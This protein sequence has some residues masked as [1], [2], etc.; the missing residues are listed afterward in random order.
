MRSST[1]IALSLFLLALAGPGYAQEDKA[2][3]I[4]KLQLANRVYQVCLGRSLK[5]AESKKVVD[6]SA[7]D[8]VKEL[9]ASLEAKQVYADRLASFAEGGETTEK[10]PVNAK[11]D[12]KLEDTLKIVGGTHHKGKLCGSSKS[13]AVCFAEWLVHR[14][15][16]A[17]GEAWISERVG[18][19]GGWS[20]GRLLEEIS[21]SSLKEG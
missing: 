2:A 6:Q 10:L 8:L 17:L 14:V 5:P 18:V 15:A 21:A 7:Q 16:P 4:K 1:K 19:L 20:Y 9:A 12:Q 11:L 13:N 3:R